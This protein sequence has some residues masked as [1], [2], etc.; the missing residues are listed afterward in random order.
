[1]YWNQEN[2]EGLSHIAELAEARGLAQLAEY[3]RLR[4]QGLRRAAFR[5]L[6]EF[7]TST[8][9]VPAA[10]QREL[11]DWMMES[12]YANPRV[13]FFLSQPLWENLVKPVLTSWAVES[14]ST[15]PRRWLGMYTSDFELLR[16]VLARTPSDIRARVA[17]V[18][19]LLRY[20]DFATHHLVESSFIGS[21]SEALADL[22]EAQRWL[23][24]VP[25]SDKR[26]A[27]G[28]RV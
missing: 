28:T 1:M 23:Q 25:P 22:N 3:C 6:D 5:A 2:F 27:I 14:D 12:W 10:N 18:R 8:L 24:E 13:H 9:K 19:L 4:E 11:A 16:D 20:V 7:I 21:E 26:D 17:L 15:I